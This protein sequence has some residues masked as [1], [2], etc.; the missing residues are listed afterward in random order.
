MTT[1][2]K[3]RLMDHEFDGIQE[4]DNPIPLW[5]NLILFGTVIFSVIYYMFFQIG[6]L[7]RTNGWTVAEA[8]DRSKAENLR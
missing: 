1:D 4:F 6:P 8:Y 5:L 7:L 2:E 3:D